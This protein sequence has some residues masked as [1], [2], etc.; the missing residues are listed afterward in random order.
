MLEIRKNPV[1]ESRYMPGTAP[2]QF[3]VD[4]DFRRD[5]KVYFTPDIISNS[6]AEA[7]IANLLTIIDMNFEGF[8]LC[9]LSPIKGR[10]LGRGETSM[11]SLPEIDAVQKW[12]YNALLNLES[13][14]RIL[15]MGFKRN[16]LQ[17]RTI[18]AMYST[19]SMTLSQRALSMVKA[20]DVAIVTCEIESGS[21]SPVLREC[22]EWL[23]KQYPA[24]NDDATDSKYIEQGRNSKPKCV[25]HMLKSHSWPLGVGRVCYIRIC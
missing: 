10:M 25:S 15:A 21:P 14:R 16:A 1:E 18:E 2:P 17:V 24:D 12:L 7:T 19:P 11:L 6:D 23:R 4:P 22:A 13:G 8:P 9:S 20:I 3:S 5:I